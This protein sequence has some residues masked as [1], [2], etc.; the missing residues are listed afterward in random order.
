MA[1]NEKILITGASGMLGTALLQ[2]YSNKYEC[3][4]LDKSTG[5][6]IPGVNCIACD[7]T[8][9]LRTKEVVGHVRPDVIIHCAALVNVDACEKDIKGAYALHV[10]ATKTLADESRKREVRIIYI[11]TDSVFN[12]GKIGAY[13]E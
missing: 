7:L 9:E 2:D 11:S 12:G 13:T 4:A 10:H 1:N 5:M 8:D 6:S 3:F